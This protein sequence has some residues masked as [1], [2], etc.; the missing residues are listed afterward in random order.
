MSD[1]TM[2]TY[3]SN[4]AELAYSHIT[5]LS[6]MTVDGV[7]VLYSTTQ[8]DGLLNG[9]DISGAVPALIDSFV[10]DGGDIAGS[11]ATIAAVQTGSGITILS[12]GGTGG[13]LQTVTLDTDGAFD[14]TTALAGVSF[15]GFQ[16]FTIITLISG[17]QIAYG[18]IAGAAG[19]GQ[20]TFD[21]TGVMTTQTQL[22]GT[23]GSYVNQISATA[24]LN[25]GGQN[26]LLT[27]SGVDN[28]ISSW[29]VDAT[30][31]LT[32]AQDLGTTENLWVS[33]PTV[34]ATALVDGTNYV[35]LGAAG[36]GSI[37]V[38]E[39]DASG[40]MII[41]DHV[42]DTL[43]TRFDGIT[44]LET[45]THNG[46]TYVIAGGA[47]DGITVFT[48]LEGG[49]LVKRAHI[50]DTTEM[51]LE[52]ISAIAVAGTGGGLD[53]YVASSSEIGLTKLRYDIGTAG[54]T[55]TATL[56][57]GILAGT[58][59]ADILQGH[60]GPDDLQAG[61][62]DDILRD[63]D[64]SDTMTGGAGADVFILSADDMDD[65]I[66]DFTLGED[67]IDLSNWSMLRDI[68]QLTM[69]ITANGVE[70]RYGDEL[71]TIYSADGNPIDYRAFT[72]ADL[73]GV[74]RIP[75]SATPGYPGP[76]TPPPDPSPPSSPVIDTGVMDPLAG[77]ALIADGNSDDLRDAFD[78]APSPSP[79]DGTA[80][81]DLIMG[82]VGDDTI[83]GGDGRDVI[84]AGGG[85][86]TV[87]GGASD[88]TLMG[89]GGDDVLEGD[90]GADML[91]GGA[92]DDDI[93]GGSGQDVLRGGDG[94]DTIS[95]G[96]GD[97]ILYG[98]AGADEF[99]FEGGSDVIADFTQ[100]EDHITL[101]AGLWT[102]LTSA[103][104]LLL[105]YGTL[106]GTQMIID[107]GDGDVLTIENVTD[108]TTLADDI[109]L[110]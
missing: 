94:N 37:S 16:D 7:Q 10:L 56:A 76:A 72:N 43:E 92:G 59:G 101:D 63:G 73:I 4:G 11:T 88:D 53:I 48:L 40:Q 46:Q 81:D 68:S 91:L 87:T 95:G 60:D 25:I 21:T 28:G 12:G 99:I 32:L 67:V 3:L 110:F 24:S 82:T 23:P 41:R 17:E 14:G 79:T 107:F 22:T 31:A 78:G 102:G 58:A 74:T 108:A 104:D 29:L 49:Q 18:G 44:A 86:D 85:N 89:R 35:L 5:D 9:W 27:A 103:A 84:M 52:N 77:T 8:Y 47:D 51:G 65:T 80:T 13:I 34:M 70:I 69:T 93:F 26:L 96:A 55:T 20:I 98:D 66:T 97:D 100:G 109:I 75:N 39:I 19:I 54:I 42:L 2:V 90:A 62:G 30:G 1:I 45:V 50:A 106:N 57:G 83:N 15:S 36:S 64:G 38:M 105:I 6:L 33:A 71:L 61:A